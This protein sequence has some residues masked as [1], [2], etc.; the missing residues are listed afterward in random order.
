MAN[1]EISKAI[2]PTALLN[3]LLK[4]LHSKGVLTDQDL[5][6]YTAEIPRATRAMANIASVVGLADALTE[7]GAKR[8]EIK[9]FILEDLGYG[10][11]PKFREEVQEALDFVSFL[12]DVGIKETEQILDQLI[13]KL[14][15]PANE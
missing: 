13:E 15:E 7:T 5:Q 6:Q 2:E 12:P 1:E 3:L 14:S 10:S 9:E 4:I 11:L 8:S